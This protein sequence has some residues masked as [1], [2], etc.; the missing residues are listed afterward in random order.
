LRARP[1]IGVTAVVALVAV[2]LG[3]AV[4]GVIYEG[5]TQQQYQNG[6]SSSY[7]LPGMFSSGLSM[8]SAGLQFASTGGLAQVQTNGVGLI[9][10]TFTGDTQISPTCSAT[11]KNSF[12]ALTNKGS[13]N[14][15]A[16]GV[17]ITYGGENNVFTI[18][19][20]CN[21][22][23]SG[24]PHATTYI[25]FK[26]PSK[27]PNSLTPDPGKPFVGTV[28]LSNG[29]S[30][31]FTG[32]FFQGY[33]QVSANLVLPASEFTQ[34]TS[35]NATCSANQPVSRPFIVLNNT[36]T[37]GE[38]FTSLTI[39]WKNEA[40]TFPILGTCYV[41]PD[42]TPGA[43]IYVVFPANSK[44]TQAA[45]VGQPFAVSLTPYFGQPLPFSG[46]FK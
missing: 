38:T 26:G 20:P 24:S 16:T 29:A 34:G 11:P 27:L 3:A 44:L 21:I 42:G 35:S 6:G 46:I 17:T 23:P 28:K 37:V 43:L 41:G 19:G 5:S 7:D 15:T 36:G 10:D 12:V 14:G 40:N 45:E 13:T 9:A 8:V 1:G 25:L 31:P 2:T 39:V 32:N 30:L 18:S 22:G 33:P 4:G